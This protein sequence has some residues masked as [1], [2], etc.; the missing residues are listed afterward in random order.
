MDI[1]V[2]SNDLARELILLE[3]I[4]PSKPTI[5]IL[6]HVLLHADASNSVR[7]ATTNM[8]VGLITSVVAQ[9]DLVGSL[10]LPVKKLMDMIRLLPDTDVRLA[11]EQSGVRISAGRYSAELQTLPAADFPRLPS[12]KGLPVKKLV[13]LRDLVKRTRFAVTE[14]DKRYFMNGALLV[15]GDAS[16]MLVA[17][18]GHRLARAAAPY[19]DGVGASAIIPSGTMDKL[20]DLAG[21][22]VTFAQT[23]RHEFFASD[24]RLLIS[25]V[26]DGQFPAW[27]RIV[28]R[29]HD[30][31]IEFNVSSLSIAL[32]RV[33]LTADETQVVS[34]SIHGGVIEVASSSP[35]HGAAVEQVPV[36]YSGPDIKTAVNGPYVLDFLN[37]TDGGT[38]VLE[39]KDEV[40]PLMFSGGAAYQC[41]I[42]PI[43]L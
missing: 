30:K 14:K 8:E 38:V 35:T 6:G 24:G 40:S 4:A 11:A 1:T 23:D 9:V 21:T 7:L 10:T 41:V 26:V 18:D 37:A 43:R 16:M 15:L 2:K 3:R 5:P 33:G 31:R 28:P 29:G 20:I 25:R 17:T 19:T 42:M 12:M 39:M 34:L 27:E 36:T 22:E 13:G 32:Q